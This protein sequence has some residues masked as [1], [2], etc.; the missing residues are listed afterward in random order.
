[1]RSAGRP[2]P[3]PIQDS[4]QLPQEGIGEKAEAI[5]GPLRDGGH[6]ELA[7]ACFRS[8]KKLLTEVTSSG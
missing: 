5:S 7:R 3:A 8:R 2:P 6:P 1:M 4:P